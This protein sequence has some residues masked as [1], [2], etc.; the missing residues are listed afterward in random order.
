MNEFTT[1]ANRDVSNLIFRDYNTKK[2][3]ENLDYANVTALDMTGDAAFAYGG[4]GHPKRV[5]FNGDKG[6][7]LKI[8]TQMQSAKMYSLMTGAN[9]EK[10]AKWLKREE[11]VAGDGTLTLSE[12]PIANTVN[13]YA[14]DDDCG[15]IIESTITGSTVTAEVTKDKTYIVYYQVELKDVH[16]LAI[17]TTTFPKAFEI[18]GDTWDKTED[19]VIL[20]QKMI[21][22]KAQPQSNFSVS[23][24]NTGD[25]ATVTITLDLLADKNNNMLDLIFD[26]SE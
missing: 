14:Y 22:Y 17:K 20:S 2:E 26:D 13:V 25:H 19:D 16:K 7:T 21:V 18:F 12:T 1:F 23:W 8:E 5:G 4:Q 9:I 24:S 15:T 6:G 10:T 3:F 11:I